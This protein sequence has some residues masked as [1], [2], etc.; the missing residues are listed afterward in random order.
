MAAINHT[1]V[2]NGSKSV[3]QTRVLACVATLAEHA[4]RALPRVPLR[5]A[6]L[7]PAL[8]D[9]PNTSYCAVQRRRASD[10]RVPDVMETSWIR[11]RHVGGRPPATWRRLAGARNVLRRV[12][13]NLAKRE[14][15]SR[16]RRFDRIRFL[17]PSGGCAA[18]EYCTSVSYKTR[19]GGM[20]NLSVRRPAGFYKIPKYNIL[21]PPRCSEGN[22]NRIL[23]N[24]RNREGL[25]SS[26]R[27]WPTRP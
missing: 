24:R 14:S 16:S 3:S 9:D 19:Q 4:F 8:P 1:S 15:P 11:P 18:I 21:L 22:K 13:Q 25:P 27:F 2:W 6:I 5:D 7:P 23:S 20:C 17:F 10:W 26:A 12:G